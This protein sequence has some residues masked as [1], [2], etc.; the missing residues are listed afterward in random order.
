VSVTLPPTVAPPAGVAIE[1][2]GAVLSI[3]IGCVPDAVVWPPLSVATPR[4]S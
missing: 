2:V 3:F 1:P 4:I